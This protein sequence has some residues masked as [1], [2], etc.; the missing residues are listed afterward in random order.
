MLMKQT[1]TSS[2]APLTFTGGNAIDVEIVW[3]LPTV[4]V[5][6]E[7]SIGDNNKP[8]YTL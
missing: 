3:D 4:S 2:D 7:V 5:S 6:L 1:I 8:I